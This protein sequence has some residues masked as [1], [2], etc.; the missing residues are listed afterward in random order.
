[1]GRT[2]EFREV[3]FLVDEEVTWCEV[4]VAGSP[5][6][7]PLIQPGWRVKPFSRRRHMNQIVRQL[8]HAPLWTAG[9]IPR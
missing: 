2:P 8:R 1:M 5:E 9:R 3:N 7:L 4:Y 6:H